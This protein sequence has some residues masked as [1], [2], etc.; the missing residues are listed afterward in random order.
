MALHTELIPA[1]QKASR[2]LMIMLHGL[3]DSIEG[4][5]WLPEA[6]NIPDLIYLFLDA[7]DPWGDGFS[8]YALP[9]HQAPGVLRSRGLLFVPPRACVRRLSA[10]SAPAAHRIPP[11]WQ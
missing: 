6:L 10:G 9:P 8:W 1:S 3:G 5:R 11:K 2:R 4:F 7:P